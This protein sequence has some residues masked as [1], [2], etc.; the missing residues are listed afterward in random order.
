MRLSLTALAALL[1]ATPDA[2]ATKL[3]RFPDIHGDRVVF[4]YAGDL[5]SAPAAGGTARQLTTHP[6]VEL[7]P[8]F[9]PD[10]RWVAFTGQ[11]EGDEQVYVVPAA[12]GVPRQLTFYPARGPLPA[13]WGYDN[14]VYGWHPDGKRILFRSLRDSFDLGSSRLFLVPAAGGLP[15][16]LPPKRS[17]AG[18]LSPDGKQLFF[19]PRFRDFRTW[20]R[21]EGGWA[22]DLYVLDLT[23]T[24]LRQITD[25]PRTDRDPMWLGDTLVFASDRDGT[26]NLYAH[27][28]GETRQLTH[29]SRWD[30]R[31]PSA[32]AKHRIV[33]EHGGELRVHDLANSTDTPI[34]ITV[35]TDSLPTRAR[36]VSVSGQLEGFELSP[37]GK[38][39]L[40]VA[41]GDLFDAPV[42]HGLTRNL[43]HSSNSHDREAEWSPDGKSVAF[44]SD[45]TGEEQLWTVSLETG[46]TTQL[47]RRLR[48]RLY[49]PRWSPDGERIAISTHDGKLL[50]V[51]VATRRVTLVVDAP[52]DRPGDYEWSPHGGHLAF[53]MVAANGYPAL[54]IWSVAG[55]KLR[56]VTSEM[57]GSVAPSWDPSGDYLFFLSVHEFS[58][59]FGSFDFNWVGNR[60]DG[61]FAFALREDVDHPFPVRNDTVG[62]NGGDGEAGKKDGEKK[63][64]ESSFADIAKADDIRIDF[65]RLASRVARVP[66]PATNLGAVIA[67]PTHL[68]L[69]DT[70][71]FYL[72]RDDAERKLV[73]FDRTKRKLDTL[74][75]GVT[76]FAVSRDRSR[77]LVRFKDGFKL[78][79]I[80]AKE[81]PKAVS[82]GG[83]VATVHPRDEWSVIFDEVW[84]RYRDH[85]Y[86]A[87]MH[88]YD[89]AALRDQYRRLLPHVGHRSDLTYVLGEMIAELSA[90]HAYVSGGDD[91]PPPRHSVALLGARLELDARAGRYRIAEIFPGQNEEKA[92]R[93]PLTEVGIDARVGDYLLAVN[94]QELLAPENPYRLLRLP[95]DQPLLL[96]LSA[97]PSYDGARQ[98]V[99]QPI[100]SERNLRYLAF[101]A[102]N[103]RKVSAATGGEVGYLHIPDMMGDGAREFIKWF[104]PQ[105]RKR[106]LIIDVRNNGG[107]FIS[108]SLIERLRRTVI[109]TGFGRNFDSTFTYPQW[110]LA[111]PLVCLID[112]RSASD[113]DIFP[114]AFREAGLGPL[115]GMRTW[116]GVVGITG[117]GPLLD[118][119]TVFVPEFSTNDAAGAYAVENEGVAPDIEVDN[120]PIALIEGRD[121]QLE[122]AV[123][124][125]QK[126]RQ[127][128]PGTLPER[129][130]D[131]VRSRR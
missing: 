124:E 83:L 108:Q 23:Q 41:R 99:V 72:G 84:R 109:G 104:F 50:S 125:I 116:G 86:V 20:K 71:A 30:C 3:L 85:F 51:E 115:I 77:V 31:W 69:H 55:G 123:A 44:I 62:P 43:T 97:K 48:A 106:G 37:K 67:T 34:Q 16:P 26:L 47:T 95:A 80:G 70:N 22:Q 28:G 61:V 73:V 101:V 45:L 56:Q 12:G 35:P 58:P 114:W 90:S 118:G 5:W 131:P 112:E 93:S 107:G 111:G 10:G 21:Y 92:Y 59:Q 94:G 75:T 60:E 64:K 105:V 18:E 78:Y 8:K 65:D 119:G 68:L 53:S 7:F 4:T 2:A 9:S 91:S 121:P 36:R 24:S 29:H 79:T 117:R 126:L 98:E 57:F 13:R 52:D 39:A 103:R 130:A 17:G 54:H 88:G 25:H 74:A 40:F 32:D 81:D 110:A 100:G 42:E 113:G 76:G 27:A 120:D 15:E 33:Y 19:S 127:T 6:G 14:Q 122:R 129:P 102:K 1:L 89:W 46:A 66:I 128:R 96:T 87:N 38:R 49:R 63:G 82:T 11:Y